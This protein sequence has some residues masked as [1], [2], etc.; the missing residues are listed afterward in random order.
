MSIFLNQRLLK[1]LTTTQWFI[2]CLV[3]WPLKTGC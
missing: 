2:S 3:L 1:F